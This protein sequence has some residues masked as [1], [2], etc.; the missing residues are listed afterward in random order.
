MA[1][2]GAGLWRDGFRG[3]ASLTNAAETKAKEFESWRSVAPGW[4]KHDRHLREA[5][6]SV[7]AA[8]LDLAG[9]R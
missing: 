4:R 6:D 9:V 2:E 7:S 3:A 5:F 1:R 8:L